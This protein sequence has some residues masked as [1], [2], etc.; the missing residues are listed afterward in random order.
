M[1]TGPLSEGDR[2]V[3]RR[4]DV[5]TEGEARERQRLA[6]AAAGLEDGG[7]P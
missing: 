1:V 4:E 5:T 3:G 7:G 6:D 2:R